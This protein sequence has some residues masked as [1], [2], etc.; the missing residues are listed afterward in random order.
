MKVGGWA[1]AFVAAGLA[2]AGC[3]TDPD[4]TAAP[5][6]PT[7]ATSTTAST[8]A[9]PAPNAM[10]AGKAAGIDVTISALGGVTVEPGGP[11]ILFDVTLSN[12]STIDVTNLGLVVSLGHCRC[13]A[14]PQQLMPAGEV[15]MLN[16]EKLTWAPV[17]YNVEAGGTDFLGRTLV[18]PFTLAGGQIVTYSL[19]LRLD[20]EQEFAVRA[21]VGA[22]DVTLTD[23]SSQ[24]SLGPS[25][26]VSLPIA[27]AV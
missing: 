17:E 13:S 12:A 6:F 11:P 1:A 4:P 7:R 24:T 15:S 14:H 2:L 27:V 20:V 19:R 22:V 26:V 3:A 23:P 9:A 8:P 25:P 21:G 10:V 18:A 5:S 16:L